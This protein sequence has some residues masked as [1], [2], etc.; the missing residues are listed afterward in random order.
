MLGIHPP[1]YKDQMNL[2][3]ELDLFDL[4]RLHPTVTADLLHP[5]V[6]AELHFITRQN[7]LDYNFQNNDNECA[8]YHYTHSVFHP[9]C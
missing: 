4:L 9:H 8:L 2:I 5:T 3:D 6:A 1:Y 7:V